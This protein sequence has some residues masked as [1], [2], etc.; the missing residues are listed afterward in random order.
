MNSGQESGMFGET[1]AREERTMEGAV[2][3]VCETPIAVTDGLVSLTYLS[4]A[5]LVCV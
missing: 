1:V 3:V 5:N 2:E 4:C